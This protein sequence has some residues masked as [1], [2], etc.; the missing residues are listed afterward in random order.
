MPPWTEVDEGR[1]MHEQQKQNQLAER[2]RG[3]GR[4]VLWAFHK[5]LRLFT[6][7]ETLF[8]VF[9]PTKKDRTEWELSRGDD[10]IGGLVAQ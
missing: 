1:E 5:F 3:P 4:L 6:S 8:F 7:S 9:P 10:R 2:E